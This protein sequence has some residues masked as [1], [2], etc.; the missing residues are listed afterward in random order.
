MRCTHYYLST[1]NCTNAKVDMNC[2]PDGELKFAIDKVG[3]TVLIINDM[4]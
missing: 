3:A 2:V 1:G 4:H